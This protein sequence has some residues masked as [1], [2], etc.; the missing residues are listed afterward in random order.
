M[1]ILRD[2]KTELSRLALM[3]SASSP[4]Q[5]SSVEELIQQA[6]QDLIHAQ[7]MFARVEDPEMIDYAIYTLKAAEERYSYLLRKLR[8]GQITGD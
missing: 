2:I 4:P 8:S 6:H 1:S 5:C 7:N 3:G